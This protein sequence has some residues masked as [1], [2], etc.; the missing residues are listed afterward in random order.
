MSLISKMFGQMNSAQEKMLGPN[1]NYSKFIKNPDEMGIN[2]KGSL[3]TLVN[4]MKGMKSYVDLM[5][6]GK[7]SANKKGKDTILGSKFF[8]ETGSK[9]IDYQTQKEVDRSL[10]IS[11]TPSGV[12]PG[13]SDMTG[14]KAS[15]FKG[16]VPGMIQNVNAIN[17]MKLF[18]IFQMSLK[19]QC[20]KVRLP[21][22]DGDHNTSTQTGYIPLIE[23]EDLANDDDTYKKY[24]SKNMQ[25]KINEIKSGNTEGLTLN[26][27]T[28][29]ESQLGYLM[30]LRMKLSNPQ[31][32]QQIINE[33]NKLLKE[34]KVLSNEQNE[35]IIQNIMLTIMTLVLVYVTFVFMNKHGR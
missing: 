13:L 20:A 34:F 27:K 24:I 2:S 8:L 12:I 21:V 6:T 1:Y 10:Y 23:L 5:L 7:S 22:I 28:M 26:E 18:R 9:C 14:F 17:P 25:D 3:P 16:L 19:P 32:Q 4:N 11:N 30:Y 31:E 35:D 29:M 33:H 15:E